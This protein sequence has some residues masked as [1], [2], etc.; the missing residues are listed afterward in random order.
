MILQQILQQNKLPFSL[1]TTNFDLR[2][3]FEVNTKIYFMQ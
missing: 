3:M 2:F 1:L